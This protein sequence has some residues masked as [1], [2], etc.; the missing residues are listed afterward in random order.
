M[1]VHA[2]TKASCSSQR[3]AKDSESGAKSAASAKLS[4]LSPASIPVSPP[5]PPGGSGPPVQFTLSNDHRRKIEEHEELKIQAR[6]V[7]QEN[8][9]GSGGTVRGRMGW[10]RAQNNVAGVRKEVDAVH[11]E[12]SLFTNDHSP[13]GAQVRTRFGATLQRRADVES[14]HTEKDASGNVVHEGQQ[15]T[16]PDPKVYMKD[17][18]LKSHKE[19]FA[20]GGN[21]MV[22]DWAHE[23]SLRGADKKGYG[24]SKEGFG[25]WG[26]GSNFV[27]S[28]GEANAALRDA[29]AASTAGQEPNAGTRSLEKDYGLKEDAWANDGQHIY[30]HQIPAEHMSKWNPRIPSGGEFGAA[31]NEFIAGGKT[32][33]NKREAVVDSVST[34]EMKARV[35]RGELQVKKHQFGQSGSGV[36]TSG[37]HEDDLH[38]V[39]EDREP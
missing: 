10:L 28:I 20:Q 3:T 29:G 30:A 15:R 18:E 12:D 31:K 5:T 23:Q 7:H 38:R 36:H 37:L 39:Q 9:H 11:G 34:D 33:G 1:K 22:S 14:W 6:R 13:K 24:G 17:S 8:E 25:G 21:A 26:K 16:Y 19:T 4:P 32:K 27:G 35:G 2:S